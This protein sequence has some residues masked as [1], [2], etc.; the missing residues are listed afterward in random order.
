MIRGGCL[1][2][3]VRFEIDRTVGPFELCHCSRCRKVS[4]SA[5]MAAVGVRSADFRF[6]AGRDLVSAYDAPI[7][8]APPAYRSTF[9]S[10]CGSPVPD[11]A[12]M[13]SEWFEIAVGTLDDDPGLRPQRHIFAHVKSCW[14][15]ISDNLPQLDEEQLAQM[16]SGRKPIV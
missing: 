3:G 9:C 10:R 7:R 15:S 5:F 4:G 13:N 11:P 14:F 2:G 16:R 1:C 6:V 8:D 12:S